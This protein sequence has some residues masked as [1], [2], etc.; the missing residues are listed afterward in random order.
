MQESPGGAGEQ[1]NEPSSRPFV[2]VGYGTPVIGRLAQTAQYIGSPGYD[3]LNLPPGEWSMAKNTAW[4]MAHV[5]RGDS[6]LLATEPE[7]A[8]LWNSTDQQWSVFRDELDILRNEGYV[9]AGD[10]MVPGYTAPVP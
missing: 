10:Y 5:N 6:F 3:V 1:A 7:G 2:P 4:V 8:N 9:R